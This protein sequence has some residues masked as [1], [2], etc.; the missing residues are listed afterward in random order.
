M[1]SIVKSVGRESRLNEEELQ[2]LYTIVKVSQKNT[3][4]FNILLLFYVEILI[5]NRN[6]EKICYKCMVF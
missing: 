1:R 3:I 4:F 5:R 6:G 2:S